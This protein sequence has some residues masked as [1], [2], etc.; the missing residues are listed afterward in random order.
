MHMESVTVT[1]MVVFLVF[2]SLI[3]LSFSADGILN[4][5][6]QLYINSQLYLLNWIRIT[7]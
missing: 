2:D 4:K 1:I 3:F 5:Q 7:A 6:L